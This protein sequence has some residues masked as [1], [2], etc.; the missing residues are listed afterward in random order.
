[1]TGNYSQQ[2]TQ[3]TPYSMTVTDDSYKKL[4]EQEWFLTGDY[5]AKTTSIVAAALNTVV[6]GSLPGY[7]TTKVALG[8]G[9][10]YND[11][12]NY[13]LGACKDNGG[14]TIAIDPPTAGKLVY[15]GT[16]HTP[17]PAGTTSVQ[18]GAINPSALLYNLDPSAPLPTITV[19]PPGNCTVAPYPLTIGTLTYTGKYT[20]LP[21]GVNGQSFFRTFLN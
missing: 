5:D 17:A 10:Y 16:G 9:V 2:I 11:G 4:Q 21:S 20:L 18:T 14:A 6:S 7:D 19:T 3:N 15:F 8:L 1:S 12:V 13:T